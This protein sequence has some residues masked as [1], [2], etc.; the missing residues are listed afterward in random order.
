M[1]SQVTKKYVLEAQANERWIPVGEY[2]YETGKKEAISLLKWKKKN[3]T[4][5]KWRLIL[6]TIKEKKIA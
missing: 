5:S 4:Q 6:R 1:K 3:H 2:P